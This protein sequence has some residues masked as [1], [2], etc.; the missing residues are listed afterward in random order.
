MLTL[1]KI[2]IEAALFGATL[3]AGL[4]LGVLAQQKY[5]VQVAAVLAF[6]G[7]KSS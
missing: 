5:P 3:T 2:G 7:K 6:F 1:F 4:Y